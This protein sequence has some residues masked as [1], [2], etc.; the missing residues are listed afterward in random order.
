MGISR[1]VSTTRAVVQS[2]DLPLVFDAIVVVIA[3]SAT[4]CL[5]GRGH[6]VHTRP[7]A[8]PNSPAT[9]AILVNHYALEHRDP[10][11]SGSQDSVSKL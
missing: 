8:S 3:L 4:G 7:S 6:V 5:V 2:D 9:F 10:I 1:S 11:L